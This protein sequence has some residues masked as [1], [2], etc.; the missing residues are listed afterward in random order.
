MMARILINELASVLSERKKLNKKE[1][2]NFVNE[3]FNL[4]QEGL[5]KDRLV[6]IKG[7]GT[8]KIIEV[9][10]RESVNVNTGERV[11]IEGH[12]KISFTP[13]ALMKE[14]VNKPFSQFETVVLNEGVD[15]A[16]MSEETAERQNEVTIEEPVVKEE[17]IN[18]EKPI[19][20]EVPTSSEDEEPSMAPLVDFTSDPESDAT[21]EEKPEEKPEPKQEPKLEPKAEVM[22]EPQAEPASEEVLESEET[23]EDTPV[24]EDVEV[25]NSGFNWKKWVIPAIFC[26]LVFVGG[27]LFGQFAKGQKEIVPEKV[28]KKPAADLKKPA[29]ELKKPDTGLDKPANE[30]T[31][32]VQKE[33][34]IAQKEE[35]TAQK[36]ET[37]D[38]YEEM[39]V[40]VRTGAYRIIGLDHTEK[41]KAGDNLTKICKRTIGN[42]MEC[43]LEVYNDIKS[44]TELKPGGEIKIPKLELKKKKSKIQ[45]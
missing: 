22:S 6:K 39:D 45:E 31:Q 40:R 4:I 23:E 20:K 9:D 3:L 33:E 17:P 15:F 16:D 30:E 27:Y 34:T 12:D 11:L 32:T 38:K 18:I 37:L 8:F 10:D 5:E 36:E 28:E 7:L 29:S 41:I 44:G 19:A 43:Y 25:E 1:A 24:E 26:V 2:S 42:G 21:P 14:L 13:D 35:V